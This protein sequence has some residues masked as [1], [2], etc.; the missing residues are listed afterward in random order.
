MEGLE[1][2][3]ILLTGNH[4][5][6]GSIAAYALSEAGFEVVG[7]DTDFY[8]DGVL[9][10]HPVLKLNIPTIKKDTRNI[11]AADLE[12]FNAVVHLAELSNDPLGNRFVDATYSVN[13]DGTMHLAKLAKEA[14]V[15]RFVYFSSCSVYGASD[16]IANEQ[17][18][19]HPLTPYAKCKVMNEEGLAKLADENFSPVYLRNATAF[20]ASPYMRFDIAV[21]NLTGRAWVTKQIKMDSDGTPWRPFVHAKDIAKAVIC[22]LNAP[23]EIIHNEIFNVGDTNANYQIKD[24]AEIIGKHMPDCEIS[25]NK[26]AVDKRNYRVDFSRINSK[27][28][29]FKAEMSVED[30]VKELIQIFKDI[31][32]SK[33]VFEAKEFTRLS[34]LEDLLQTGKINQ[35]LYWIE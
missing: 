13:H 35:E 32:L 6:L 17:S 4:G 30:G 15:K 1:I 16:E 27:L 25:F 26:D 11:E 3:K 7:L 10:Q 28:P 31:D 29:G 21:N 14:G 23:K 5:Y 9:Y 33:E 20:G 8:K 22:A 12:G 19:V 2:M 18:Q 34:Q 24:I